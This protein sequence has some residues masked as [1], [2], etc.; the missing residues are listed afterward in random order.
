MKSKNVTENRNKY[1][2]GSDIPIILNISN[3]KGKFDLLLEKGGVKENDFTGNEYTAYGDELEPKIREF[4]NST[5]S[6]DPFKEDTLIKEDEHIRCNVDGKNSDT[7]LEIKTTSQIHDDVDDYK[8]YLVQLLFYMMNF[9]YT[10]GLL[11][12]YER[13]KDFDTNFDESR[14]TTYN[15]DISNYTDLCDLITAAVKQFLIDLE[16]VKENPFITEEELIPQDIGQLAE[17]CLILEE[18]I[19]QYNELKN[20]YDL[21]KEKLHAAMS[22]KGIK[23]WEMNGGTKVTNVLDGEDTTKKV[24]DEKTFKE[25][26]QEEYNKYLI[27]KQ[28][29]GRKGYIKFTFKEVE[30]E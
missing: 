23:N 9:N 29:K 22:E 10:K 27:D 24:F 21:F 3:F 26:H 16:K 17:Q 5:Y 13:P 8:V 6:N 4:I 2:G 11:A 14:L 18:Q 20:K 30:N 7:I 19:K 15:I 25:E 12:V 28:V 1:I